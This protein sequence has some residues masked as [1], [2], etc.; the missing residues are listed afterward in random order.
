M[1]QNHNMWV[2]RVQREH[3][4]S[5][6]FYSHI[7]LC[8]QLDGKNLPSWPDKPPQ[9]STGI[10]KVGNVESTTTDHTN[11]AARSNSCNLGIHRPLF[12]NNRQKSL[13]S[14]LICFPY[15]IHWHWLLLWGEPCQNT[16]FNPIMRTIDLIS[17]LK[18]NDLS[19]TKQKPWIIERNSCKLSWFSILTRNWVNVNFGINKRFQLFMLKI[20]LS[21]GFLLF[22]CW[23]RWS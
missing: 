8:W 6:R 19:I 17:H 3:L 23:N 16:Q 13:L 20:H 11:Q 15:H 14:C 10:T 22:K 1:L 9:H 7:M 21:I 4:L 18:P 2:I 12:G 5:H